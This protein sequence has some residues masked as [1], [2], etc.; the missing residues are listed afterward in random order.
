MDSFTP[1]WR[2]LFN[3]LNSD[4]HR[5]IFVDR[6]TVLLNQNDLADSIYY[7][8]TSS[9]V[10][11]SYHRRSITKVVDTISQFREVWPC[12]RSVRA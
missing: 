10:F 6:H 12:M 4:A 1:G 5:S 2:H 7:D 8:A 11:G 9:F 3:F